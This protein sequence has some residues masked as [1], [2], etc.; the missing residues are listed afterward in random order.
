MVCDRRGEIVEGRIKFGLQ[1]RALGYSH[2]DDVE[3]E[4]FEKP[5]Q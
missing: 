2:T 5:S 4:V 1:Q 3:P